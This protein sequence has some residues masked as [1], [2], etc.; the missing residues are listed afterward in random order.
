[1]FDD[2]LALSDKISIIKSSTLTDAKILDLNYLHLIYET[3]DAEDKKQFL[4]LRT[5]TQKRITELTK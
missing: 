2:I 1:M 5:T 4:I 3:P